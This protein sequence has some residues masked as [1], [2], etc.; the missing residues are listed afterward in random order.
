MPRPRI[1]SDSP[2]TTAMSGMDPHALLQKLLLAHMTC[3]RPRNPVKT[4][5]TRNWHGIVMNP[6]LDP[7]LEPEVLRGPGSDRLN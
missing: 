6:Q 4:G 1:D 5:T 2:D 7:I 3:K